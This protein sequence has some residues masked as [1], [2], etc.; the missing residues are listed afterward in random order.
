MGLRREGR[1]QAQPHKGEENH[2]H[3]DTLGDSRKCTGRFM[4]LWNVL[5]RSTPLN[6]VVA[7]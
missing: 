3:V 1:V 2:T 4:M 7:Y 5:L 6:G